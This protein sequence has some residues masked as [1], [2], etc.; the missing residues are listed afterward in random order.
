MKNAIREPAFI[1][2]IGTGNGTVTG[3]MTN[4]MAV[5]HTE[6]TEEAV[7]ATVAAMIATVA[8]TTAIARDT[9]TLLLGLQALARSSDPFLQ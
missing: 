7:D 8:M 3:L 1:R 4:R 6:T 9:G 5:L 2:A